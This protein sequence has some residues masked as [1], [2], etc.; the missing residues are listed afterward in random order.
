MIAVDLGVKNPLE[1]AGRAM[2]KALDI[3]RARNDHA[4]RL[5]HGCEADR[6]PRATAV[7]PD[8][9]SDARRLIATHSDDVYEVF[10]YDKHETRQELGDLMKTELVTIRQQCQLA[11]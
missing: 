4:I 9:L 11:V 10:N 1:Q 7:D 2:T 8:D 6:S 5:I 3:K